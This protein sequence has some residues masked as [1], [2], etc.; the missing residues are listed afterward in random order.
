MAFRE[1]PWTNEINANGK[2]Y[3][4]HPDVL[5]YLNVY[6]NKF[7]LD[8]YI[9]YGCNVKQL[10]VSSSGGSN[11]SIVKDKG[12]QPLLKIMLEWEDSNKQIQ[13]EAFDAVCVANGHYAAPSFPQLEGLDSFSGQTMHSITYDTPEPFKDQVVLCIGGRASGSDLAREILH[14]A[15]HVYL[16]DTTQEKVETQG[17]VTSSPK[18]SR[19]EWMVPFTLIDNAP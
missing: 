5:K 1:F 15:K 18:L 17:N 9:Q 12:G 2:L 10:M 19:L 4:T 7:E 6:K 16:S 13:S 11:A 3:V 14:C 8:R